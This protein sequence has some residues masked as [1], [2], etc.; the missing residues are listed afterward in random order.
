MPF[1]RNNT[2]IGIIGSTDGSVVKQNFGDVTQFRRKTDPIFMN[3]SDNQF[4]GFHFFRPSI[5]VQKPSCL[6]LGR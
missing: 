3:L 1:I 6:H 2:Y 5:S 4:K